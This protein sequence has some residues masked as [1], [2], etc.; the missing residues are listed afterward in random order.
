MRLEDLPDGAQ[1]ELLHSLGMK[2]PAKQSEKS[3]A[4]ELFDFQ[5]RAHR[6]AG[7][8]R[9][10]P[11]AAHEPGCW[12]KDPK[13][14]KPNKARAWRFDFAHPGHLLAVEIEG[15]RVQV[16][17]GRTLCTGR[18]STVDGYREDCRKYAAAVE[19]GWSVLRFVQTQVKNGEAIAALE[20][21]FTRRGLTRG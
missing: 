6:F 21:V 7:W 19:L 18:H 17:G 4:A 11:F 5:L 16:V 15:L 2:R 12:P 9:E 10:H 3:K 8:T 1:S 20:R 14:P 13:D